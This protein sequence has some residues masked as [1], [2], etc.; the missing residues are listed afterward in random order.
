VRNSSS[1]SHCNWAGIGCRNGHVTSL[2]FHNFQIANP[3]PAS[4]CSL[5]NL[6][7]LDLSYNNLTGDFPTV[8]YNCSALQFLDLSYNELTGNL[9]DNIDKLPLE[10]QH[11][12]LSSNSFMGHV[13][14]AIGRFS[15]LKSLVLDTN[16][17]DGSYPGAAIGGLVELQTLTLAYNP[18]MPGPIPNEFR[19]LTKMTYLWLSGTNLIG[20]IN[21]ALSALKELT[22]LDLS[23]NKMQGKIPEWVWKLEK[24]EISLT[25]P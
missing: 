21:D 13:P 19:K 3:I 9:P 12:N 14:L 24:L 10:M 15:K 18:L 7:Y 22:L 25:C 2:S 4:I 17:F 16:R 1:F 20:D 11:L 8:L 6:K 23:Q 5:K